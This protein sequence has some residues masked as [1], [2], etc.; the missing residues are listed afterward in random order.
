[1]STATQNQN[2]QHTE[3][4]SGRLSTASCDDGREVRPF[5]SDPSLPGLSFG[6][7]LV[8]E[9]AKLRAMRSTLWLSI[10]TVV[11][12]GLMVTMMLYSFAWMLSEQSNFID[13]MG[14]DAAATELLNQNLLSGMFFAFILIGCIGVLSVTSEFGSGS[15]RSTMA[16][17]PR[18][19]TLVAAKAAALSLFAAALGLVLILGITL[20]ASLFAARHDLS[21]DFGDV[22]VW[23]MLGA[24]L[25]MIVAVALMGL[26]LGLILRSSAGAIVVL[27]ALLFVAP[28][29][30]DIITTFV[31]DNPAIDLIRNWQFGSLLDAARDFG[32]MSMMGDSVGRLEAGVGVAGWLVVSLGLGGLL[33]RRRDV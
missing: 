31:E 30:M 15:I 20:A 18:R 8:S 22:Q 3:D 25:L 1:M 29:A 9:F 13:T 28:M 7:V 21:V 26:G 2:M 19:L 16:A 24:N 5:T 27:A 4:P 10:T 14:R 33:F 6:R 17:V 32:E 23:Q 12:T 11:L